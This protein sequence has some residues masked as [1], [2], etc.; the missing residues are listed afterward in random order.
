MK[1]FNDDLHVDFDSDTHERV[2]KFTTYLHNGKEVPRAVR[3]KTQERLMQ[4]V[5]QIRSYVNR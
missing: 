5:A 1:D 2:A 4:R 3:C